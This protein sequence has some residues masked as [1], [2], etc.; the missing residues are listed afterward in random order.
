MPKFSIGEVCF[1]EPSS[2]NSAGFR[3]TNHIGKERVRMLQLVLYGEALPDPYFLIASHGGGG[4]RRITA[5]E[6][7]WDTSGLRKSS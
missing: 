1:A 6:I 2:T 3:M 4:W 7:R 5:D